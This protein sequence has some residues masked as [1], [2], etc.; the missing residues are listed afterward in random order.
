MILK[1][2]Q[3]GG[4]RQLAVHLLNDRDNEHASLHALRGFMAEDLHGALLESHAVAKGTQCR[5]FLFSLS[6]NPPKGAAV[7]EESFERAIEEAERRLGLEGQPRAIVFH[8]KEGRRHAHAVW[9]RIDAR[10]M[11]AI[12]LPFFKRRLNE[13]SRELYIEHEWRLPDGLRRDKGKS[14]LNFSLSEWQQAKRLKLDPREIK[15]AFQ[16]AWEQSDGQ[17]AFRHALAERGYFLARGDRRG[18][19]AL[20]IHG[21]VFAIA[22]WADIRTKDV[23]IKLGEPDALPSVEQAKA[24]IAGKIDEKLRG[25]VDEVEQRYDEQMQPLLAARAAF[26]VTHRAHRDWLRTRQEERQATETQARAARLHKGLRG[27]WQ[28]LTGAARATRRRNEEEALEC[29]RRDRA[30]RDALVGLPPEKWSSVK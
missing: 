16:T 7:S 15:D 27:L 12:N 13:L 24:E 9:S 20:D 21:E 8:E 6:F 25:F 19:V 28:M 10:T 5:Q 26:T 22:R 14:P 18:F 4:A 1:G 29:Q 11:Q 17:Q 3:R 23:R 30:E 2:S